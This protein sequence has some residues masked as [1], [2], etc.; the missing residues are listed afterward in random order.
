MELRIERDIVA[1]GGVAKLSELIDLGHSV[2]FVRILSD[3]G[4]LTKVR[5]GWYARRD[6]PA[7]AVRAW[8][9]GGRLACVS[10][11]HH[12]GLTSSP[13]GELHVAVRAN[14]SRLRT[15]QSRRKRLSD[16]PDPAVVVHWI[17]EAP[18]GDRVTVGAA[19]AHE[20]AA[21]CWATA[22]TTSGAPE[23]R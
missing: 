17:S 4:R 7:Q 13:P 18:T 20:Q 6:A 11:L 8:R 22:T 14:A 3:Y 16:H 9:V 5:K 12:L 2:E 10:A 23:R 1:I 21:T 15:P 19:A